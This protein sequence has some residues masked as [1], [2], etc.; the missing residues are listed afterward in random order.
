LEPPDPFHVQVFTYLGVVCFPLAT[1]TPTRVGVKIVHAS[2]SARATKG[3][4]AA[5]I[6]DSGAARNG[7][8]VTALDASEAATQTLSARAREVQLYIAMRWADLAD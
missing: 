2:I 5:A 1:E 7:A 6:K 4:I 8:R 3:G